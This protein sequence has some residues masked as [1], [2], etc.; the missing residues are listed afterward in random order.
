MLGFQG[1][2][3][4]P[5]GGD[6]PD[7]VISRFFQ[8][9]T[10]RMQDLMESYRQRSSPLKGRTVS[11]ANYAT[12][13]PRSSLVPSRGQDHGRHPSMIGDPRTQFLLPQQTLEDAG[14]LTVVLDLDETLIFA[15]DVPLR[16]RPHLEAL[17]N[18][19]GPRCEVV[20]WTAGVRSYAQSVIRA[21]DPHHV[22]R[23]CIYR[24]DK[25]F[26]T[27]DTVY[28]K[29]IRLLG[30]DLESVIVLDNT[31]DCLLVNLRNGILCTDYVEE[32]PNDIT[33]LAFTDL[34]REYLQTRATNNTPINEF[35]SSHPDLCLIDIVD[36]LGNFKQ[37]YALNL[38][39]WGGEDVSHTPASQK[40]NRDILNI[41]AMQSQMR[42]LG[43]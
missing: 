32:D 21:I 9:V 42:V 39:R 17:L 29:D 10:T 34:L 28:T 12:M 1:L 4:D 6:S 14:K 11:L 2:Y 40:V 31:P 8:S 5:S 19:L 3:E 43:L 37:C 24:H 38:K 20:V 33:L 7:I 18:F 41:L 36:H 23:H 27:T 22:I 26:C 15:R 35:I 25:W 30:R 16:R 13:G